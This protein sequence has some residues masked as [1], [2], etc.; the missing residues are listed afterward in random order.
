MTNATT[1]TVVY[2]F[3]MHDLEDWILGVD[4]ED[5]E[6]D[7]PASTSAY[8][9]ALETA[10]AA[11]FPEAE[12]DVR[13]DVGTTGS[14]PANL[15]PRYLDTDGNEDDDRVIDIFAVVESVDADIESWIVLNG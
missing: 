7:L 8:V 1:A 15:K 11:A 5:G 2:G 9:S 12:I 10:L 3:H 6:I 13:Y 14:L 4:P